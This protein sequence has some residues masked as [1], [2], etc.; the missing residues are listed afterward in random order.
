MT[1]PIF[2][3]IPV[4]LARFHA[5][6]ILMENVYIRRSSHCTHEVFVLSWRTQSQ[7]KRERYTLRRSKREISRGSRGRNGGIE[8]FAKYGA[9][10]RMEPSRFCQIRDYEYARTRAC[11]GRCNI[12]QYNTRRC[13]CADKDHRYSTARLEL[14]L[15]TAKSLSNSCANGRELKGAAMRGLCRFRCSPGSLCKVT[16]A[17]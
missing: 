10:R 3:G 1:I 9:P 15:T 12:S 11:P 14:H 7:R 17:T 4:L 13:V 6:R 8:Q 5:R 16:D 2:G